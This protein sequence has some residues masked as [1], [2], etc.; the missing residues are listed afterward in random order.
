MLPKQFPNGWQF[1]TLGDLARKDGYG[2]VDGP[3]GSNLPASD[4][5]S[6]GIP[7]IRGGNLSLGGK[8]FVTDE[9]VYVSPQTAKRL[10]R[11]IA[12]PD[13]II[14]TKK[15]TLGQTGIVPRSLPY[16]QYLTSSNQ[17]K[18]SVDK[19]VADP[20]FIYYYVSSP[21]SREKI[22]RDSEVT[23]V[24]KTNLTYLK[25]F[26]ILLPPLPE[27]RAIAGI[28]G[29]LDDKIEL[30]RRMN[31]T[32]ES[33]A[34]AVFRQWFVESEDV[35]SWEV[36][37]VG[38]VVKRIPVG[39]KYDFKTA[40]PQGATPI[41]DQSHFTVIGYHNEE[42]GVVASLD[43]PVIVFSNH[44][45]YT[46]IIQFPF[47]AI[48]NVLPFVGKGVDTRWLYHATDGII[49]YSE[50]KGHYPE[51]ISKPLVIPPEELTKKFGQFVKPLHIK[52]MKNKEESR[53]LASLRDSLLPKLMRGEVRVKS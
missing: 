18:L 17:M 14:F 52:I 26:P 21:A 30:N 33:M 7:V 20:L 6:F 42:P 22:T 24:P 19:G 31:R 40:L 10:E 38:D 16:K 9:F 4:Y 36:G 34:R 50:Y 8:R 49:T 37:T 28:L 32:L 46:D 11:S 51:F 43:N 1:T 27:Q 23:G 3:F 15:G 13:D 5:V 35:E 48:Q 25:S 12:E 29:A 39:K 47:S 2:L 41:L 53:T 44:R 45:C